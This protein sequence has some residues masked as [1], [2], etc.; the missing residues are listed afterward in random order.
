MSNP[1]EDLITSIE[2]DIQ[3]WGNKVYNSWCNFERRREGIELCKVLGFEVVQFSE[4][5]KH[6]SV[7]FF[8]T[9]FRHF[10]GIFAPD[11]TII[12]SQE[13]HLEYYDRFAI[14]MNKLRNDGV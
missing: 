2:S 5:D 13:K 12:I 1:I 10:S 14:V 11:K 6:V 7:S 8:S 3:N 4:W 9:K